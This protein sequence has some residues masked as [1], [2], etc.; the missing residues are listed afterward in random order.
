MVITGANIARQILRELG[1]LDPI[2]PGDAENL[3]DVL[4]VVNLMVDQWRTKGLTIRAEERRQHTLTNAVGT[5]T[6]GVGGTINHEYPEDIARWG[7]IANVTVTPQTELARGRPL[8]LT[9]WQRISQKSATGPLP[10][11]LYFDRTWS[12]HLGNILVNP[13]PNVANVGIVLYERIPSVVSIASAT[14]YDLPP[15]YANAIICK[16]AV[17]NGPRSGVKVIEELPDLYARATE[18]FGDLQS[19]NILPNEAGRRSEFGAIGRRSSS[20]VNVTT[21]RGLF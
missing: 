13:I 1:R 20:R 21:G 11:Y 8:T 6:V 17:A 9:E 12:A 2:A 10:D 16:G 18:A 14:E 7:V 19:A 5:Y 4:T 15:G 3:E